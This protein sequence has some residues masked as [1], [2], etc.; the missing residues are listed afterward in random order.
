MK[1]YDKKTM[2]DIAEFKGLRKIIEILIEVSDSCLEKMFPIQSRI[3]PIDGNLQIIEFDECNFILS[4]LMDEIYKSNHFI[5]DKL[6]KFLSK[7][8]ALNDKYEN[9]AYQED[10]IN[11]TVKEYFDELEKWIKSLDNVINK[12]E[13][14]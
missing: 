2:I 7:N 12:G 11:F 10:L 5:K 9:V 3:F 4:D 14:K 8:I 1:I 13:L 6:I